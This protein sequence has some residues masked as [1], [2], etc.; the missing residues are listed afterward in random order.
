[1]GGFGDDV[2]KVG[3]RLADVMGSLVLGCDGR[4]WQLIGAWAEGRCAG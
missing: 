2:G 1:M 3:V 4:V